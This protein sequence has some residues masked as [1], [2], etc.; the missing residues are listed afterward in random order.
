M[1]YLGLDCATLCCWLGM[2]SLAEGCMRHVF[3]RERTS[4]ASCFKKGQ[5]RHSN[6]S[7]FTESAK[8]CCIKY[9]AVPSCPDITKSI[10]ST[11]IW[12]I[13]AST[14]GGS[15]PFE[16]AH[17]SLGGNHSSILTMATPDSAR[18]GSLAYSWLQAG[19]STAS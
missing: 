13:S 10:S 3:R 12:N 14:A 11:S 8:P 5:H 17:V 9:S 6:T 7:T 18:E 15:C 16:P 4:E 2:L 1:E 19:R